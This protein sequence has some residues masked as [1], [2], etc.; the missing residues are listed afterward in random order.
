M[1]SKTHEA[2]IDANNIATAKKIAE[3]KK[4]ILLAGEFSLCSCMTQVNTASFDDLQRD[5]RKPKP[6]NG[7]RKSRKPK[8]QLSN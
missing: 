6:K 3:L 4:K 5:R 8:K 2:S 1:S 7:N